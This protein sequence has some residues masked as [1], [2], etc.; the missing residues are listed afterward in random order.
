VQ[1]GR[2]GRD[3]H[4]GVQRGGRAHH[5]RVDAAGGEQRVVVGEERRTGRRATGGLPQR[6]VG[7]G[8]RGDPHAAQA[9]EHR[10]VHELRDPAA[11]DEGEGEVGHAVAPQC[12]RRAGP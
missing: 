7:L 8:E 5:H 2:E 3:R 6:G 1:A 12:D 9:G 11:A 10:Q 4:R